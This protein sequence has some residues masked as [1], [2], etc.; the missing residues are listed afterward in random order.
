MEQHLWLTLTL[1]Q[2]KVLHLPYKNVS[3]VIFVAMILMVKTV[4]TDSIDN[5][6]LKSILTSLSA[7]NAI[8]KDTKLLC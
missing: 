6:N 1:K 4:F 2:K 8:E 5:K 3:L 7:H